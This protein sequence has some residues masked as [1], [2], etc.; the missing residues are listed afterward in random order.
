MR[1]TQREQ[2]VFTPSN[3]GN[4]EKLLT[5]IHRPAPRL[6]PVAPRPDLGRRSTCRRHLIVNGSRFSFRSNFGRWNL[7][8]H[9]GGNL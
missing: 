4:K 3:M 2:N 7:R 9:S 1:L 5:R 6:S 8:Q